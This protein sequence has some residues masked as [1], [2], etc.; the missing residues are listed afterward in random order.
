MGLDALYSLLGKVDGGLGGLDGLLGRETVLNKTHDLAGHKDDVPVLELDA[1]LFEVLAEDPEDRVL[2]RDDPGVEGE[3]LQRL[4]V[5][6][7]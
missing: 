4:N 2:L 6:L 7:P 1:R 3:E 5:L